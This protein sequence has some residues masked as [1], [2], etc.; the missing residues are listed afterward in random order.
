M[1]RRSKQK[2]VYTLSREQYSLVGISTYATAQQLA[3]QL[4]RKLGYSFVNHSDF[5]VGTAEKALRF[6]VYVFIDDQGDYTLYRL[7]T[8]RASY[9]TLLSDYR[10]FDLLLQINSDY[11]DSYAT[12]LIAI[13]RRLP[14]VYHAGILPIQRQNRKMRKLLTTEQ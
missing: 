9:G 7:I 8:N 13:L 5:C 12:R 1:A 11:A 3:Q 10:Q 6:P 4:N 14:M 2:R